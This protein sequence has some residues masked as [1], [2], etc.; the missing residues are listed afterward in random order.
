MHDWQPY[1]EEFKFPM[2]K[3]CSG[4][5]TGILVNG[6]ELHEKDL[7]VLA[8][9]GLPTLRGKA[10]IVD[11]QG[12]ISDVASGQQLKGLGKL[13]PSLVTLSTSPWQILLYEFFFYFPKTVP[14]FPLCL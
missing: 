2:E 8:K 6:R 7:D 12:N 9:R 3:G 1:I 5:H 11:I 4:G 13:A 14:K 10:Y